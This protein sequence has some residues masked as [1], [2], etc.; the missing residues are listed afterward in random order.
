MFARVTVARGWSPALPPRASPSP[1]LPSRSSCLTSP[2]RKRSGSGLPAF[3]PPSA[4]RIRTVDPGGST[5]LLRF[6]SAAPPPFIDAASTPRHPR[7]S[8]GALVPP[9]TSR[10]VH[11]VS[12]RL[13]GFLRCIACESVSPRSGH[14]VHDLAGVPSRLSPKQQGQAGL[15]S[16]AR[17]LR[18][19]S[20]PAAVLCHHS[21]FH[22]DVAPDE[23]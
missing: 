20:S 6:V 8:F 5:P 23:A 18:S 16:R 14:G 4:S 22:P 17:T 15:S 7:V 10:S 21:R 12:H 3:C 19:L 1:A 13:D 2:H 11:T 9:S